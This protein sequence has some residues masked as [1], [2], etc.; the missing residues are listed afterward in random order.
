M[1][2][3]KGTCGIFIFAIFE[4]SK[5]S[6]KEKSNIWRKKTLHKYKPTRV[7]TQKQSVVLTKFNYSV[8][9][10]FYVY[11][12]MRYWKI[13]SKNNQV[14][15]PIF[16]LQRLIDCCFTSS[17]QYLSC[18]HRTR[19]S[20]IIYKNYIEMRAEMGQPTAGVNDIWFTLI[21]YV[22]L[23]MDANN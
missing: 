7:K 4:V 22:E 10:F 12:P 15:C 5:N 2:Y 20:S 23:D 17:E 6:S 14:Y 1:H 8:R 11:E 19:T 13:W 9:F 21:T 18:I 3:S 16:F